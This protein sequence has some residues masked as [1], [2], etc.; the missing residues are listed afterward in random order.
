MA[1]GGLPVGSL[2]RSL[3]SIQKYAEDEDALF[4]ID[5]PYTAGGKKTGKRPYH[6]FELDHEQ[7]FMLCPVNQGQ[8]FNDVRQQR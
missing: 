8:C 5:P 6:H 1:Y 4:F 3:K 2:V 7:L